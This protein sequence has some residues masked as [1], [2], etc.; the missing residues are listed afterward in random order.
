MIR[1]LSCGH[2]PS[3]SLCRIRRDCLPP[4]E[5]PTLFAIGF[6][7]Y[8]HDHYCLRRHF[9]AWADWVGIDLH[10][11]RNPGGNPCDG[12]SR[13]LYLAFPA[14]TETTRVHRGRLDP[15]AE[16]LRTGVE[17]RLSTNLLEVLNMAGQA[18][19]EGRRGSANSAAAVETAAL[20]IRIAYRFQTI[21][22]ARLAGLELDLPQGVRERC[23]ALE[24][25]YCA[26]LESRLGKLRS[27][28]SSE[29]PTA[30]APR[31]RPSETRPM[32]ERVFGGTP[33]ESEWS[34]YL[35]S[36]SAPQLEAYRR[37]PILLSRLDSALSKIGVW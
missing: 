9:R 11:R 37:L 24:Q 3:L 32:N 29:P 33:Q 34:A 12:C 28:G 15:H 1:T 31:L 2:R 23:A 19:L 5:Y 30:E 20:L 7:G 35:Y 14:G 22:R 25:A 13:H 17:R 26:W 6:G 8:R 10:L 21:A 27:I 16:T 36:N 4:V 18:R